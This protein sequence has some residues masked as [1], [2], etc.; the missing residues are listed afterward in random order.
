MHLLL[1]CA[2][3]IHLTS[4][5]LTIIENVRRAQGLY[6]L[7]VCSKGDA[8]IASPGFARFDK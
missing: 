3:E 6:L 7:M 5:V 8:E 4:K 2:G 1:S